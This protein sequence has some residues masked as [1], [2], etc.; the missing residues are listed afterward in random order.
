LLS[1]PA[2]VSLSP[3]APRSLHGTVVPE[4]PIWLVDGIRLTHF[5]W[6]HAGDAAQSA[7]AEAAVWLLF[8]LRGRCGIHDAAATPLLLTA[9][10]HALLSPTISAI[11][12][13]AEAAET[14]LLAIAWPAPSFTALTAELPEPLA[15]FSTA[16]QHHRA[17]HLIGAACPPALQLVLRDLLTIAAQSAVPL[18]LLQSR[19]KLWEL[20]ALQAAAFTQPAASTR[21]IGLSEYDQERLHFAHDYLLQHVQLPPTLPELAR[22]AGLNECKLKRGF[23]ALFGQPTF[24]YLAEWRLQEARQRLLA[25]PTVTASEVAFELGYASLPHFSAAFKHRFG[26][27]PR[28]LRGA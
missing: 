19:A 28:A 18:T 9:R 5:Q 10:R 14:E 11:R 7:A 20:V 1:F 15:G 23:K 12:F 27:S 8:C 16:V 24:A 22:I 26:I 25:N 13:E 3:S 2:R 17:A 6:S 21:P 4:P